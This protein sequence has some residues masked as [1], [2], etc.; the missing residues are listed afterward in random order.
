MKKK[1]EG[2]KPL[3]GKHWTK[4]ER[5]FCGSLWTSIYK[6]ISEF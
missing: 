2:W 3:Q 1:K 4:K 5:Y 6:Q